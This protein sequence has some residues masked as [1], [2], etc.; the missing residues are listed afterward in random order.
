MP[1]AVNL[2]VNSAQ[3]IKSPRAVKILNEDWSDHYMVD[4]FFCSALA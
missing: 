2:A 1:G 4:L 3:T